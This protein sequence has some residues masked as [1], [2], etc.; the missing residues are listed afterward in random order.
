MTMP[1]SQSSQI[2]TILQYIEQLNP[3]SLLDVGTGMGQYGFLARTNLENLHLFEIEGDKGWQRSKQHWRV[4]IDGIEACEVYLTPVHDYVYNQIFMGN[5]LDILPTLPAQS[6]DLVLAIDILEHFTQSDAELFLQELRR[7]ARKSV[8][9]STP[10]HFI[11]QEVAA[12]PYENHR[13]L[14]TEEEL[15]QRHYR[16]IL[17]NEISWIAIWVSDT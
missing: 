10:K 9:L 15:I 11:P 13:S 7:V 14:W 4:Q 3:T 6:Y 2:S 12:N 17:F 1:F 5:A 16:R 8:I